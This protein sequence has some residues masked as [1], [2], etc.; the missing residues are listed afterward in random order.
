MKEKIGRNDLCWCGSKTK[1]KKCHLGRSEMPRAT[2]Q[3]GVE[4][5]KSVMD[6]KLCL[7]ANAN[8]VDCKGG[9]IQAHT[10][11]RNGS[12]SRIAR[13]GHVYSFLG[14]NLVNPK[15][16]EKEQTPKLIGIKN[17]STFTGFCKY[18]DNSTFEVIEKYPFQSLPEHVFLLSYRVL[19]RELYGKRR[20]NSL[21][22]FQRTLDRGLHPFSQLILQSQLGVYAE[23]VDAGLNDLE[24]YKLLYD[25]ALMNQNYSN[26][27]FYIVRFSGIP[28]VLCSAGQFPVFDFLG[29]RLQDL[30]DIKRRAD[31][32][33]FSLI[34]TD[35]GEVAIFGWF[36][37]SLAAE[38][39][40][41]SLHLQTDD[42][43]VHSIVRYVF[44]FFEN[45]Y[46]SPDWWESLS[47]DVKQTLQARFNKASNLFEERKA[48]CLLD[49]GLRVVN[50]KVCSRE[51]NLF[52]KS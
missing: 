20:Q 21:I 2:I 32:I 22:P 35:S 16:F 31:H 52:L 3:E 26:V 45:A 47:I 39:L 33:T 24:Y 40:I 17:A 46:Y 29:N 44:E 37:K 19:C 42:Q 5:L 43:I 28:S 23:G 51:T 4:S 6:Y 15:V 13:D 1:Y 10:L 9:I 49:D 14:N 48:N 34:A 27:Y 30:G 36:G 7:H 50:W 41:K 25:E 8:S 18:H 38:S 11:Q 12:L